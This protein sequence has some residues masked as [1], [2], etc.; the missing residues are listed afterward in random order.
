MVKVIRPMGSYH[1][2]DGEKVVVRY[3]NQDKT[4]AGCHRSGHQANSCPGPRVHLS[5]FMRSYWE[6]IGY[7]PD[8]SDLGEVEESGEEVEE[9]QLGHL[10][11]PNFEI[12][13]SQFTERYSEVKIDGFKTSQKI[14]DIYNVLL[15]NGLP[16][17]IMCED[18]LRNT[19]KGDIYVSG[20]TPDICLT[21]QKL[22]NQEF[23]GRKVWITPLVPMT[24]PKSPPSN[25]SS[26]E[27]VPATPSSLKD[28]VAEKL[29]NLVTE[30]SFKQ[31][32]DQDTSSGE[33]EEGVEDKKEKRK[34]SASKTPENT[35]DQYITVRG[36]KNKK[37]HKVTDIATELADL[38]VIERRLSVSIHG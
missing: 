25:H 17:T 11:R 10:P 2:I 37:K 19:R 31:S 8:N 22:S 12:P 5:T 13:S 34:R 29:F 32:S 38:E 24:P 4:C 6:E 21:L 7:V 26:T 23:L 33:E 28:T 3:R 27:Q 18:L 14:N 16:E 30:K 36:K 1:I 35:S 20:L 15:E 9:V